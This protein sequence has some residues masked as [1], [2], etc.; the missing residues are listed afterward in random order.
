[1]SIRQ[2]LRVSRL[3]RKRS[4]PPHRGKR[5]SV[6]GLAQR[7]ED[8]RWRSKQG[9]DC[10]GRDVNIF[11]VLCVVGLGL[12]LIDALVSAAERT[13]CGLRSARGTAVLLG[14]GSLALGILI[15]IT[16]V[17]L[18][19]AAVVLVLAGLLTLVSNIKRRVLGEPLVFT[20]LALLGAVFRHPQFYVSALASWQVVA[21][22][23]AL[24]GLAVLIAAFSSN[25]VSAR[26][27]GLAIAVA[28]GLWLRIALASASWTRA[29]NAPRLDRDVS[30]HGLIATLLVYWYLWRRADSL[31]ECT[32]APTSAAEGQILVVVQCESFA[33]PCDLFGEQV[34]PLSGL[35][36]ARA[37]AWRHGRLKVPG[38][39]AYTMRTE[40]GVIFGVCEERLGLRRYDPFLTARQA[41]SWS[42]PHRLGL[43]GWRHI[44]MHPHDLR[45]YGRDTIMPEAGFD[46]LVGPEAFPAPQPGEGRYVTD[47][48]LCERLLETVRCADGRTFV[49]AVTIENHGPWSSHEGGAE[50][51]S[52][53]YVC[54]LA[55][56][57]AMLSRLLDELPRLGRPVTLCFFG[58]HRP[59]IPLASL[60]GG[61]RHTPYV[62]IRVDAE[63][64]LLTA[65]AGPEDRSPAQLHGEI[66]TAVGLG[67]PQP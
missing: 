60:P 63:G 20:D 59:S 25:D 55:R 44:F 39:G 51:N 40:F 49:Y 24:A 17:F 32:F 27:G 33:D 14:A 35:T 4:Y 45:F 43:R 67:G 29:A 31:E 22:F 53:A 19:S 36:R 48:V 11:L 42:L 7:G 56:S 34:A 2:F 30:E 15:C 10:K 50:A 8:P 1:M 57:D 58:D 5:A 65:A 64:Q 37:M 16:G 28:A 26:I 12:V 61:E 3:E 47:A 52:Q 46:T 21:L 23:A 62:I 13:R 38:F 66:L 41:A 9:A 54:K 6:R 18:T